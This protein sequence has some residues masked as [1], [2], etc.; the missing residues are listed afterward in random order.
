M[1]LLKHKSGIPVIVFQ[2]KYIIDNSNRK[3]KTVWHDKGRE[4]F[5]NHLTEIVALN[6]PE[7]KNSCVLERWN[8]SMKR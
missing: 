5:N 6:S 7:N 8:R 3:P 2:F 4:F 1:R